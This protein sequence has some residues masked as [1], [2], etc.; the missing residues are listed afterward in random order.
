MLNVYGHVF[1]FSFV[2]IIERAII[3]VQL[4]IIF[5]C[6]C[7]GVWECVKWEKNTNKILQGA[8]YNKLNNKYNNSGV[9][10]GLKYISPISPLFLINYNMRRQFFLWKCIIRFNLD[11]ERYLGLKWLSKHALPKNMH[12]S[13]CLIFL[14]N[15]KVYNILTCSNEYLHIVEA[16]K[17]PMA[18]GTWKL[19]CAH[20]DLSRRRYPVLTSVM[21]AASRCNHRL[22]LDTFWTYTWWCYG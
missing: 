9:I 2:T 1:K 4:F 13:I 18:D 6:V 14:F 12:T 19:C 17:C 20:K 16:L 10:C 22:V 5:I 8:F 7:V 3:N 15:S 21:A 11:F